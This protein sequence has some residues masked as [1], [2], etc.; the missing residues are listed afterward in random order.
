[1]APKKYTETGFPTMHS[2]VMSLFDSLEEGYHCCR[3]DNLY[4]S[5]TF[6]KYAYTHI[7]K[8]KVHGVVTKIMRGIPTCVKQEEEKNRKK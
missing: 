7:R 5:S 8:I 4:Y 1:M 3:M 2:R 6:C